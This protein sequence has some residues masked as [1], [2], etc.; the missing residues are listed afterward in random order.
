MK[1]LTV[2]SYKGGV[3]KSL[4][5]LNLAYILSSK[6]GKKVGMIDLDVE[7]AGLWQILD[8]KLEPEKDLLNFLLPENRDVNNLEKYV[9]KVTNLG[10]GNVFLIPTIGDSQILAKL[11]WDASVA[12]FLKNEVFPSFGQD[13]N[14]DYLLID[15]RAGLSEFSAH[16]IKVAD[17]VL[18]FSR[19]GTQNEW[20]TNKM[21]KVC[22]AA[23]KEF[24]VIVSHCPQTKGYKTKVN[25]FQKGIGSTISFLFPYE[26]D[27]YF[28]EYVISQKK[29]NNK[30]SKIYH[31]LT[32]KIL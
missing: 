18:L 7:S 10:Q 25:K 16:A 1:I 3:G 31:D 17:I 8:I 27:L 11:Q 21:V 30:L 19:L 9:Y 23:G 20:G 4:S 14:L 28:G 2:Y 5:L 22:E 15:G 29:P 32:V 12:I 6:Y 24:L 26:S 13:Y